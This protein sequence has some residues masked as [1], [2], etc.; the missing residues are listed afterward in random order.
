MS[1]TRFSGIDPKQGY[2]SEPSTWIALPAVS[3]GEGAS[4]GE[5]GA[6][7]PLNRA[8]MLLR[9]VPPV[10]ADEAEFGLYDFTLCLDFD[11]L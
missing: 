9:I 7:D 8:R 11:V 4:D 10:S 3:V 5:L 6:F 2:Q 1:W